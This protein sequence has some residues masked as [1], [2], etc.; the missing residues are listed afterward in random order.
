MDDRWNRLRRMAEQGSQKAVFQMKKWGDLASAQ[1]RLWQIR[2]EIRVLYM[3][4][5]QCCWEKYRQEAESLF[6]ECFS[7][8]R[9]LEQEQQSLEAQVHRGKDGKGE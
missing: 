8:I 1:G 3:Q 5:G 6:S 9:L 2:R 4:I 7:R